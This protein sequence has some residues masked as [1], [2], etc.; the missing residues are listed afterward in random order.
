MNAGEFTEESKL[1]P[2]QDPKEKKN[3]VWKNAIFISVCSLCVV[4]LLIGGVLIWH[5]LYYKTFFVNGQS[6]WPTLNKDATD[7]DGNIQGESN[8]ASQIGYRVEF[9]IMDS[10]ENAL[11]DIKRNNIVVTYYSTDY[12]NGVLNSTASS[13][14]KRVV[15]LPNETFYISTEGYLFVNDQFVQNL[16]IDNVDWTGNKYYAPRTLESDEYFVM[17]D[18]RNNSKDSRQVGPIKKSYILGKVI[19]MEGTCTIAQNSEC[20]NKSYHWPRMV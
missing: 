10:H 13:K 9:G 7:A 19:A 6:M 15:A 5:N 1:N 3:H 20:N 4:F 2:P 12:S 8:G 17:G 18:N 16:N 11:N 14:I